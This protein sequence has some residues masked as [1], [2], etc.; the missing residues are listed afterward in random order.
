MAVII[1]ALKPLRHPFGKGF[2]EQPKVAVHRNRTTS[3][4]RALI[5]VVPVGVA[6]WEVILNWKTYYVGTIAYNQVYYQLAAKA[7]EIMIQ[8]SLAAVI[9]SN[10]R[11]E[12]A[13]GEG[14]PFG[15]LFS[16]LQINQVSYLW[17]REFWGSVVSKHLSIR[18]KVATL[19]VIILSFVLAAVAGPSSA[20]LLI[21]RL[22]YWPAGSTHIWVNA[23]TSE[24]WPQQ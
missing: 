9:F 14:L 24:I 6:L 19:A 20:V 8:A 1:S 4:L 12:M 13:L 10:V 3:I 7:H 21:P 15:A 23:T 17:S 16:G 22:D 11:H 5:H 18:R 2:Q